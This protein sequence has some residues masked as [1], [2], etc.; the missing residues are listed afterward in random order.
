MNRFIDGQ[1]IH[2]APVHANLSTIRSGLRRWRAARAPSPCLGSLDDAAEGFEPRAAM[3][4][5]TKEGY[6]AILGHI[7]LLAWPMQR[8]LGIRI[9]Q[10]TTRSNLWSRC[11]LVQCS[12]RG[13]HCAAGVVKELWTVLQYLHTDEVPVIYRV[14]SRRRPEWIALNQLPGQQE[15]LQFLPASY[16]PHP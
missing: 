12:P 8:P 10:V 16:F 14:S 4:G 13:E 15:F 1:R 9:F 6:L 7:L 5:F 3:N 11:S 2:A